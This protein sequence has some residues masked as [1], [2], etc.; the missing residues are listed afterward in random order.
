MLGKMGQ[1]GSAPGRSLHRKVS[2]ARTRQRANYRGSASH[3][4]DREADPLGKAARPLRWRLRP[5]KKAQ[6]ESPNLELR[7]KLDDD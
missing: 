1:Q 7:A 6:G 2:L 3:S 4:G 5:E